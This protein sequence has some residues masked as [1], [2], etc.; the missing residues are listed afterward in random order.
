MSTNCHE[1]KNLLDCGNRNVKAVTDQLLCKTDLRNVRSSFTIKP[2]LETSFEF[3]DYIDHVKPDY[4]N[5]DE[6]WNDDCRHAALIV[7][8]YKF[9]HHVCRCGNCKFETEL[10]PDYYEGCVSP[11][12]RYTVRQRFEDPLSNLPASLYIFTMSAPQCP[13]LRPVFLKC[14][15]GEKILYDYITEMKKHV[16]PRHIEFGYDLYP[17]PASDCYLKCMYFTPG[18]SDPW[19]NT[20][21]TYSYYLC[22]KYFKLLLMTARQ[23]LGEHAFDETLQST[24][25]L[26]IKDMACR[27]QT[28]GVFH[29][30]IDTEKWTDGKMLNALCALR[31]NKSLYV[32]PT[33]LIYYG[34]EEGRVAL[35]NILQTFLLRGTWQRRG[36]VYGDPCGTAP[37]MYLQPLSIWNMYRFRRSQLL[38]HGC[39]F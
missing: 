24:I 13:L 36:L 4:Q 35:M 28:P 7:A 37:E 9:C 29:P 19:A 38:K 8:S 3:F 18:S 30:I 32:K 27:P 6:W 20:I 15:M 1:P 14:L 2:P 22:R 34:S 21:T 11:I 39:V 33:D 16:L 12:S 25:G 23:Y 26:N 10:F 31:Q 17:S 5:L